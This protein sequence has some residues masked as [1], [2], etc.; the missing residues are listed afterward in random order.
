MEKRS[1]KNS[2]LTIKMGNNEEVFELALNFGFGGGP[3]ELRQ[4]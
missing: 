2:A 3:S 1:I 4:K